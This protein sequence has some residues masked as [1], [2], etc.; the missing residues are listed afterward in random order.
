VYNDLPPGFSPEA[1]ESWEYR[2]VYTTIATEYV[3]QGKPV[4]LN[5]LVTRFPLKKALVDSITVG[6]MPLN[7][8][9]KARASALMKHRP[10]ELVQSPPTVKNASKFR[11]DLLNAETIYGMEIPAQSFLVKDL[12]SDNSVSLLAGETG[13]GKSILGLNLALSVAIGA[14]TWLGHEVL[15]HGK[16]LYLNNELAFQDYAWRIKKMCSSLP[17]PGDISNLIT[18]KHVPS[19]IECWDTLD[20]TCQR[21]RPCLLVIDCLYFAHDQDENDSSEMKALMRQ[22]LALRDTHSMAIVVVHHTKKGVRHEAMHFDQM[23][24]S[25]V[26]AGITDTVLQMRRSSSDESKRIIKPTKFRHVSDEHRKCR[27]LSLNPESLWFKDEGEVDERDHIGA[28]DATAEEAVNWIELFGEDKELSR[29]M[30]IQRCEPL[31][32]EDRTIDRQLRSSIKSGVLKSPR[33][34]HYAL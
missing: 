3:S 28:S 33:Y 25:N 1:F 14:Q 17:C 10:S 18:P 24:G 5:D 11:F 7:G 13:C 15:R 22:V 19:L 20:E 30:I 8:E 31:G 4:K 16:V 29:K 34:G 6:A 9:L 27:L 12:I 2:D 26:F 32:Y 23:R 21:E